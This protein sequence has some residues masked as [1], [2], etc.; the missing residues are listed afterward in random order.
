LRMP[1]M[2]PRVDKSRVR[3]RERQIMGQASTA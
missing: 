3:L 1:M 2:Q